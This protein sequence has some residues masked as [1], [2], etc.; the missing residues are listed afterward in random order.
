MPSSMTNP[1]G[2]ARKTIVGLLLVGVLLQ[3]GCSGLPNLRQSVRPPPEPVSSPSSDAKA[4][5]Q[6]IRASHDEDARRP[7]SKWSLK[8]FRKKFRR[9]TSDATNTAARI[10]VTTAAVALVASAVVGFLYLESRIDDSEAF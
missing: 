1:A 3:P 8:R 6:V 4:D 5:G 2:R 7:I 10:A 9:G